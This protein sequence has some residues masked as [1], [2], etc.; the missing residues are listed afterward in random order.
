MFLWRNDDEKK[1]NKQCLSDTPA[2]MVN[3]ETNIKNT[4]AIQNG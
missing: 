3:K 1:D 2:V 4:K